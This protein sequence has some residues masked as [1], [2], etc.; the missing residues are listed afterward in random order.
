MRAFKILG[1]SI[2]G[3]VVLLLGA[4]LAIWLLF[5]PNDYKDRI[6]AAVKESTGRTLLLPGELKL[7]LFPWIAVQTGEASLGNP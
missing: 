3:L 7:S 2:A 5:D 1:L 4:L 6:T